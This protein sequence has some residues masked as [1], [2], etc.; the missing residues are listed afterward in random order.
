MSEVEN[1]SDAAQSL[2]VSIELGEQTLVEQALLNADV[3]GA[4][5]TGRTTPGCW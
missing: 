1:V 4:E 5:R 2:S 3:I